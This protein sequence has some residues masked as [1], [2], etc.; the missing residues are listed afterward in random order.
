[1]PDQPIVFISHF[2]VRP[3]HAEAF[4]T[5][6][7]SVIGQLESAKPATTAQIAYMDE[8]GTRLSIVHVFPDPDALAAHFL[9]SD[10]RSRAVY[11]HIAPAGWEIYGRPHEEQL[12]GLRA[13]ATS[14]GV[15]LRVE[16]EAIGG[17]LRMAGR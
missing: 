8:A 12:A 1:M 9:G 10:E 7:S 13:E 5:M 6:W 4:R 15:T 17:F 16:P 14:A 3:G 11:E 2:A